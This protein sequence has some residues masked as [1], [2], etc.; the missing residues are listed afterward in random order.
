[1]AVLFLV[2]TAGGKVKK[3]SFEIAT[4]AAKTAN[5]LGTGACQVSQQQMQANWLHWEY[6]A[7]RRLST[8]AMQALIILMRELMQKRLPTLQLRPEQK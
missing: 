3:A 2:E 8:Q 7:P 6:M 4:Y 1:M 5:A